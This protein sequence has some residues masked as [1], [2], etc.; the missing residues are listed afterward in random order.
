MCLAGRPSAGHK[1]P[2]GHPRT[3]A[4]SERR[5]P[6]GIAIVGG[7]LVSQWLT[8]YTTPIY[9]YL[10]R[11]AHGLTGK[12]RRP[13]GEIPAGVPALIALAVLAVLVL[14]GLFLLDRLR[15]VSAVQDCLMTR[16]GNCNGPGRAPI[17]VGGAPSTTR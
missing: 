11:F 2:S 1:R 10:D 4:G 17:P 3:G 15:E 14:A 12:R 8:L 5:R 7:L 6:L 16:A 13:A 9:L